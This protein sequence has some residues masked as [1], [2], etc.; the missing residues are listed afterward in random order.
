MTRVLSCLPLALSLLSSTALAGPPVQGADGDG[1]VLDCQINGQSERFAIS[2]GAMADGSGTLQ[3]LAEDLYV[4]TR[5]GT[6]YVIDPTGVQIDHGP[7]QG[8]WD[9]VEVTGEAALTGGAPDAHM[10]ARLVE[11]EGEVAN[12]STALNAARGD[13]QAAILMRDAASGAR[14]AAAAELAEAQAEIED[15]MARNAAQEASRAAL[16][17]QLAQAE[18]E[19]AAA[20]TQLAVMSSD[21]DGLLGTFLTQRERIAELQGLLDEARANAAEAQVEME[22]LGGDLN[23]AL[24]RLAVEQAGRAEAEAELSALQAGLEQND[25]A[26]APEEEPATDDSAASDAAPEPEAA[27]QDDATTAPE[28]DPQ[29]TGGASFD[30]DA[31]L[32]EVNAADLSP[33][34]RAALVA[35]IEQARANPAM[36]QEVTQRL[37]NALSQ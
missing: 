1:L 29:D 36:L 35:A 34:A 13:R 9:C 33:I 17:D 32:A 18:A 37:R 11:L 20:E 2:D 28:P 22:T 23:A 21:F 26:P 8:K 3:V 5:D 30:A 12:L 14:D 24:A 16:R 19:L 27:L 31:A 6:T 4:L 15:L 10:M 7:D 25:D